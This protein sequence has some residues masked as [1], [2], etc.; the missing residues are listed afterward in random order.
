MKDFTLRLPASMGEKGATEIL[1][2]IPNIT[3]VFVYDRYID[4]T[5]SINSE[6]DGKPALLI[7]TGTSNLRFNFDDL[8]ERDTVYSLIIAAINE[9]YSGVVAPIG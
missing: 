1:V 9:Y 5:L 7:N 3:H 6:E 4:P 2:I 8:Q